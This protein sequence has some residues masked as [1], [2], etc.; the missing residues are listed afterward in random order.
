MGGIATTPK[1]AKRVAKF[2]GTERR[3]TLLS[4]NSESWKS[5]MAKFNLSLRPQ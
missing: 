1:A 3:D 5:P 2:K 4:K